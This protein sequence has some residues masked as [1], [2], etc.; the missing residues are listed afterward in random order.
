MP[1]TPTPTIIEVDPITGND[2]NSGIWPRGGSSAANGPLKTLREAARRAKHYL[3]AYG[4]VTISGH[5]REYDAQDLL[6]F[7][8]NQ[9]PNEL[10]IASCRFV[11]RH[12]SGLTTTGFAE[13][14]KS[15]ILPGLN[16]KDAKRSILTG[17]P[18]VEYRPGQRVVVRRRWEEHHWWVTP[19]TFR[20]G[21]L[22]LPTL[23][24][25]LKDDFRFAFTGDD[26]PDVLLFDVDPDAPL[27]EIGSPVHLRLN[28]TFFKDCKFERLGPETTINYEFGSQSSV[29]PG[30][31][32]GGITLGFGSYK[33]GFDNCEFIRC[34][35]YGLHI[36]NYCR[37]GHVRGCT[38]RNCSGGL[39]VGET[40]RNSAEY[41]TTRVDVV[42]NKIIDPWSLRSNTA[43]IIV[44]NAR[45]VRIEKNIVDSNHNG[46]SAGWDWDHDA[47]NYHTADIGIIE[48]II[49]SISPLSDFGA[50]YTLG[51]CPG[52][53]ISGNTGRSSRAK[54][55]GKQTYGCRGLYFDQGSS[56]WEY[57]DNTMEAEDHPYFFHW[58]SSRQQCEETG[59][60]YCPV[61]KPFTQRLDR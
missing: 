58:E 14:Y 34:P 51:S 37:E 47:S 33:F 56:K 16:W 8:S 49:T 26:Y 43:G 60:N 45:D 40:Y 13:H 17:V 36:N 4:P 19:S 54:Q 41:T 25:R 3:D 28:R 50:I 11:P 48:N 12:G 22:E 23:A 38:F 9:S 57:G 2:S 5:N 31:F 1:D 15:L 61:T 20:N 24:P 39:V 44:T 30:I 27:I 29:P 59:L 6:L 35:H 7:S 53:V 46:I 42:G 52:G 55:L 21:T 18:T 10:T 32:L